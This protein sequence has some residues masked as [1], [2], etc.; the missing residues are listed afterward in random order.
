[1]AQKIDDSLAKQEL[2]L[3]WVPKRELGNQPFMGLRPTQDHETGG[4][5]FPACAWTPEGGSPTLSEQKQ[6]TPGFASGFLASSGA[7]AKKIPAGLAAGLTT[8]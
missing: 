8:S 1:M 4:T 3:Q 5:G 2:G 6:R 7:P